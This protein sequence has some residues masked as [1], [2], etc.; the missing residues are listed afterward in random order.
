MSARSTVGPAWSLERLGAST[1]MWK[2][3]HY[4]TAT[5]TTAPSVIAP[6][7]CSVIGNHEIRPQL[8]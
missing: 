3:P 5:S 7:Q 2:L 6:S 4:D 8:S 1:L